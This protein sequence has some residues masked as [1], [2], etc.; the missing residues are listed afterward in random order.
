MFYAFY[1]FYACLY[2]QTQTLH[3]WSRLRRCQLFFYFASRARE[4]QRKSHFGLARASDERMLVDGCLQ[5]LLTVDMYAWHS[6]ATREAW[7]N[8]RAQHVKLDATLVCNTWSL[9]QHSCATREA[10]CNTR[11]QHV[12]HDATLVRNTWSLM[13]HSCATRE[14][15]CNTRAQHVKLWAAI[16]LHQVRPR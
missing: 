6:C 7:C 15:W 10:W 3:F 4:Q 13:Q 1:A 16:L 5:M 14:A 8:T 12:K 11:V 2:T 9:M